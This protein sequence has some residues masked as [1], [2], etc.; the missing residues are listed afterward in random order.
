MLQQ[1]FFLRYFRG[2]LEQVGR[3]AGQKCVGFKIDNVCFVGESMKTLNILFISLMLGLSTLLTSCGDSGHNIEIPG[4]Q[5]PTVSLSGDKLLIS[6]VFENMNIDGGLRFNIPEYNDSYVELAPDL[7][8]GGMLMAF[9]I[10]LDDVFSGNL[11]TLDP[12]TLPGGRALPGVVGG[13][14]PAVAFSIEQFH[15]ISVYLGPDVFGLFVPVNLSIDNTIATFR[16]YI[17][18]KRMGNIS[19]VGADENG[20]NG[21]ILLLLDMNASV[22]KKLKRLAASK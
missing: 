2:T 13:K 9:S 14:L 11:D 10:D 5:G 4:V 22:V 15:N 16:Y 8:S 17:G 7:Q 19:L 21:G 12:Q 20:E 18:D 6:M 1:F 3:V